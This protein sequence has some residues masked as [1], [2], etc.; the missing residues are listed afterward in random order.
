MAFSEVYQALQTGVVDGAENTPINIY[1]QKFHEVQKFMSMTHHGYDGYAIVANRQ[2][3]DSLPA[4]LRS[5][6]EQAINEATRY[7]ESVSAQEEADAIRHIRD[8]GRIQVIELSPDEISALR[9][10]MLP[11]HREM[12]ARIGGDVAASMYQAAGFDPDAR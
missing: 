8:S 10:T 2:F 1:T 4:D 6:L 7:V 5:L 9:K 3:W 12:Q 11:V